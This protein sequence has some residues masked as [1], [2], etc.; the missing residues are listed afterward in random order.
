[1]DENINKKFNKLKVIKFDHKGKYNEKYYLFECDC[2]NKK[3]IN[4]QNVK[5][6]KTK[7][8]GCNYKEILGKLKTKVNKYIIKKDY[9]I[10][11]S[12][13]TNNKFY[14]DKENYEKI[15]DI[16]WYE[17]NN[18]YMC[19][20]EKNKKVILLHRYIMNNP[21]GI[22]D[23]I[24]HN[25]RDNR[26]DNLRIVNYSINSLNRKILPKGIIKH[27]IGNNEYY[28]VQLKGYRGCY[29]NYKEAKEKRNKII[30]Q[31]YKI[32]KKNYI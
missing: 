27:K 6:G 32:L 31:E 12:T 3:V 14:I 19:H 13:N 5:T 24:N 26:K 16:S 8:C 7:S 4:F 18:G 23:H 17:A 22:V 11:Y 28:I 20:K 9:I 15:K 21:E 30:E 10:G 2:G 25:K 29:K 1:M